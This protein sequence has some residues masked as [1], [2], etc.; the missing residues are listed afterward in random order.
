MFRRISLF[1]T[2][3]VALQPS[4]SAMQQAQPMTPEQSAAMQQTVAQA[5][6]EVRPVLDALPPMIEEAT[7]SAEQ[8]IQQQQQAQKD[9]V[10]RQNTLLYSRATPEINIPKLGRILPEGQVGIYRRDLINAGILAASIA[11]HLYLINSLHNARVQHVFKIVCETSQELKTQLIKLEK[12]QKEDLALHQQKKFLSR[13]ISTKTPNANKVVIDLKNYLIKTHQFIKNNPI[14][15][16]LMTPLAVVAATTLAGKYVRDNALVNEPFM[17]ET[18]QRFQKDGT[19]IDNPPISLLPLAKT[20]GTVLQNPILLL[21]F[22]SIVLLGGA[23]VAADYIGEGSVEKGSNLGFKI[24]AKTLIPELP[25][26]VFSNVFVTASNFCVLLYDLKVQDRFFDAVW[27]DYVVKNSQEC[28]KILE[29][30]DK[31]K[32]AHAA[33]EN[34]Q[35]KE[36]LKKAEQELLN[37]IKKGHSI[38]SWVP[39][40]FIRTWWF[41]K[42]NPLP[43]WCPTITKILAV[44]GLYKSASILPKLI[45]IR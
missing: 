35:T 37:F 32:E 45:K 12:I 29:A 18:W 1:L 33:Q 13:L 26:F 4:L 21:L 44:Y 27:S 6:A 36:N 24:A 39:G 25:D 3:L 17:Q 5:M 42:Q 10:I 40:Q 43:W 8:A 7:S 41:Q 16:E 30:Y 38:R 9:A 19:V 31:A 22:P 15:K 20:A 11:S 14:K 28:I 34:G 2:F 23:Y